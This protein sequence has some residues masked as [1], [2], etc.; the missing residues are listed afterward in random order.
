MH[1]KS[2]ELGALPALA[3]AWEL[4]DG[5]AETPPHF[6]GSLLLSMT[7]Q[8]AILAELPDGRILLW[9]RMPGPVVLLQ[10]QGERHV[11]PTTQVR[12]DNAWFLAFMPA[13]TGSK[14][15]TLPTGRLELQA[16]DTHYEVQIGEEAR[17]TPAP[18]TRH[19]DWTWGPTYGPVYLTLF[20]DRT[21]EQIQAWL[22]SLMPHAYQIF[23]ERRIRST[24]NKD[25][26]LHLVHGEVWFGHGYHT[27]SESQYA[28]DTLLLL[29]A[30]QGALGELT[31]DIFD[32]DYGAL[33]ASGYSCESLADYL[34]PGPSRARRQKHRWNSLPELV[35][36][37]PPESDPEIY[38]LQELNRRVGLPESTPLREI[39]E[40]TTIDRLPRYITVLLPMGMPHPPM[41]G[42]HLPGSMVNRVRWF[43][44]TEVEHSWPGSPNTWSRNRPLRH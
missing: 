14:T 24:L 19:W 36:T 33:C 13:A 2:L 25:S 5:F 4:V 8:H 44:R 42:E 29:S 6:H 3:D 28:S 37:V 22:E 10:K 1:W 38:I 17:L 21:L 32:G 18:Q 7:R 27:V 40:R 41:A 15:R 23:E 16:R 35:I 9:V 30:T 11:V 43:W 20:V 26:W 34:A 39:F 31:F 12:K